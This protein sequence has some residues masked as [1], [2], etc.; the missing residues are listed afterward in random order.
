M[1]KLDVHMS[2]NIYK[3][4][5]LSIFES[6]RENYIS[7]IMADGVTDVLTDCLTDGRT[8]IVNSRV[9]TVLKK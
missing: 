9:A 3:K 4:N 6:S 5:Q 8:D 7:P 1:Y 2:W